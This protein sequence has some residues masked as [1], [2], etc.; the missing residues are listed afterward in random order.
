MYNSLPQAE[1]IE[2][3]MEQTENNL[4]RLPGEGC[5]HHLAERCLYEEHLNPGY[6]EQWLCVLQGAWEKAF[7]DFLERAERF[8]LKEGDIP[9]LWR[10]RFEALIREKGGCE[11]F[12]YAPRL[13]LPNCTHVHEQ[14]CVLQLPPCRGRCRHFE[15]CD[16]SQSRR[17]PQE[18]E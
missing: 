8:R 15:P 14:L 17:E 13:Q 6:H 18:R 12:A 1:R 7:D 2:F 9:L 16:E 4:S 10:R 11:R 3:V 5:R